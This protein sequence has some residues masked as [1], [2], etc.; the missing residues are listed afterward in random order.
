MMELILRISSD[1]TE[2]A[3]TALKTVLSERRKA[4]RD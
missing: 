2:H 1:D 3:D 4:P